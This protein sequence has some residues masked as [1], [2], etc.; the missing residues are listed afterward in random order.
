MT[1]LHKKLLIIS[2]VLFLIGL[3]G[4]VSNPIMGNQTS[5]A[6]AGENSENANPELEKCESP[7]G[8]MAIEEDQSAD[9]WRYYTSHYSQLGSTIPL[10]RLYIQQSNCF[11]VV[12]RGSAVNNAMQERELEKSGELRSG[13]KYGKGQMVAA[14]FTMKPSIQF[15]QK[16]TGG[17]GGAL[18]SIF[19]NTVGIIA[20]GFRKNEASTTLI[21]IDNR[22]S[23]QISAS[24][25]SAQN[26]DISVGTVLFGGSGAG[27]AGGFTNTPEGKVI[28]AA[29]MDSYNQMVKSLRNYKTQEVKGGLGKGGNLK[30]GK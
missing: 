19:G 1:F 25:G 27:G 14:D 8:S 28:A 29:F 10:L 18:G 20:G 16:G 23:V 9:W 26:Y 12:E 6:A 17:G 21:L 7:L 30:I 5:S 11:V 22:S 13:S 2:L 4:C 3:I 24:V 15:S